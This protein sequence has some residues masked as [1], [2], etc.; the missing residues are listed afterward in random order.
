MAELWWNYNG[1]HKK[2]EGK[3][4]QSRKYGEEQLK[5]MALIES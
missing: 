1:S 5:S 4:G 2:G 3:R